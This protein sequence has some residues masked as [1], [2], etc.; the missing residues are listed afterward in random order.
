MTRVFSVRDLTSREPKLIERC[1]ICITE[2]HAQP[3]S[4]SA[5][6]ICGCGGTWPL[7]SSRCSRCWCWLR[8]SLSNSTSSSE[9]AP[10][11]RTLRWSTCRSEAAAERPLAPSGGAGGAAGGSGKIS[12]SSTH[13]SSASSV[14]SPAAALDATGTS[15]PERFQSSTVSRSHLCTRTRPSS[16]MLA[17][18]APGTTP[19]PAQASSICRSVSRSVARPRPAIARCA[20]A[21][22]SGEVVRSRK[23]PATAT[24][25]AENSRCSAARRPACSAPPPP[26]P[27]RAPPGR[28][29][30]SSSSFAVVLTLGVLDRRV[31]SCGGTRPARSPGAPARSAFVHGSALP[32]WPSWLREAGTP[33][34]P[35]GASSPPA[36]AP[37]G[38]CC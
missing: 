12:T 19:P 26:G 23:Q 9:M 18:A 6:D 22:C 16:S 37:A 28:A 21:T 1:D 4:G 3:S 2:V 24:I 17:G 35:R 25:C 13:S 34:A 15:S 7:G 27:G 10:S 32:S 38:G 33:P 36:S 31:S 30:C 14:T 5:R 8:T 20:A 29:T 11:S